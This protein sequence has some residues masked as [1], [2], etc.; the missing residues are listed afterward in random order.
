MVVASIEW[1]FMVEL[2]L[3]LA[4]SAS[5]SNEVNEKPEITFC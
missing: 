2:A 3:F 4:K 1:E 5:F